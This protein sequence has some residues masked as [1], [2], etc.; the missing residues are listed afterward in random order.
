MGG[1]KRPPP[2]V[3]QVALA[4]APKPA[5]PPRA[6]RQPQAR[7]YEEAES[8]RE[9]IGRT[10]E[11]L[12]ERGDR[13]GFI[14]ERLGEVR[15]PFSLHLFAILTSATTQP[16]RWQEKRHDL[17]KRRR[18]RLSEKRPNEPSPVASPVS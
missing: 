13:L 3:R 14:Q 15:P 16:N 6:P 4:P 8:T 7:V 10:N 1:P 9:V 12:Q 2:K 17:R 5:A 11:A 18:M